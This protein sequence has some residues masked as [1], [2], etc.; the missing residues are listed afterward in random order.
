MEHLETC[1]TIELDNFYTFLFVF[2]VKIPIPKGKEIHTIKVC[3]EN[4]KKIS[5]KCL[6]WIDPPHNRVFP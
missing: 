3:P 1:H 5:N 6:D 2:K 4:D